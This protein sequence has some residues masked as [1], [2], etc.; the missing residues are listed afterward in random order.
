MVPLVVDAQP[1]AAASFVVDTKLDRPDDVIDGVCWSTVA[2]GCT[3]RAAV[4][5]ANAAGAGSH[6]ITL[7]PAF[8]DEASP[9]LLQAIG[10]GEDN[11]ATGDLDVHVD[12]TVVGFRATVQTECGFTGPGIDGSALGDRAWHVHPTGSLTLDHVAACNFTVDGDGGVIYNTG[13]VVYETSNLA[14]GDSFYATRY[15]S[16]TGTGGAVHNAAEAEFEVVLTVD[17]T[18]LWFDEA[19]APQG[20]IFY[21]SGDLH[22]DGR[23]NSDVY[24]SAGS[25]QRGGAI[26]NDAEGE[27][28]LGT[29]VIPTWNEATEHGGGLFNQ[30]EVTWSGAWFVSNTAE[31]GGSVYNDLSGSIVVDDSSAGGGV[32]SAVS[33]SSADA[34]G[35]GIYN[36]GDIAIGDGTADLSMSFWGNVAGGNGGALHHDVGAVSIG[37]GTQVSMMDGTDPDVTEYA[38][39]GG[40]IHH[41]GSTVV[42]DGELSFSNLSAVERGGG[43]SSV[44]GATLDVDGDTGR[45]RFHSNRAG[46]RGGGADVD[47]AV[48]SIANATFEGNEAPD[49]GGLAVFGGAATVLR[50]TFFDNEATTGGGVSV[51]ESPVGPATLGVLNSTFSANRADV[52]A[53]LHVADSDVDLHHVTAAFTPPG[54]GAAI[55]VDDD[56]GTTTLRRVLLGEP[57]VH[58]CSGV[59]PVTD[60]WNVFSDDTCGVGASDLASHDA[61]H[62]LPLVGATPVHRPTLAN[63]AVDYV[64][65]APTCPPPGDDQ[66][67]SLRPVDVTGLGV[68]YCDAG[69]VELQGV[70]DHT[71]SGRVISALDGA[72]L[73]GA[74]VLVTDMDSTF[75]VVSTGAEGAYSADGLAVGDYLVLFFDPGSG[76]CEIPPSGDG[77]YAP[78]LYRNTYFDWDDPDE[79]T[80]FTVVGVGPDATGVNACLDVV[81]PGPDYDECVE[82]FGDRGGDH[83]PDGGGPDD[84]AGAG[85]EARDAGSGELAFTGGTGVAALYALVVLIAGLVLATRRRRTE[86]TL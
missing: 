27:L 9:F 49:G 5:E 58:A 50:S 8:A 60:D 34:D 85:D 70:G 39:R 63:P 26:F 74:C 62:L 29:R 69:A 46:E 18:Y 33:Y 30:G 72:P 71:I 1:A 43:Y 37:A 47:S 66:E 54:A 3:L 17:H 22:F 80:G 28:L 73:V 15:S 25:A 40:G 13:R 41:A 44:Q 36:I 42:V 61:V 48:A 83:P 65:D 12:I 19:T 21:N 59:S 23:P 2:D 20:G 56:A 55:H 32:G 86:T 45:M 51:A 64:A 53:A 24:L 16:A 31:Y 82:E 76:G 4:Q 77:T 79:P 11:A 68:A 81:S 14:P 35:G 10:A 84:G 75:V 6:T 57:V 52:G 38:V 78:E 7:D 67:R